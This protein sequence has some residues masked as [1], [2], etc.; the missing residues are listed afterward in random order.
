MSLRS[1]SGSDPASVKYMRYRIQSRS[2]AGHWLQQHPAAVL[3]VKASV[4][5][6]VAWLV[7]KPLGGLADDY[8]YYA[9]LGAVVATSTTALRS[10]RESLQTL[11]AIT[12]GAAV[13]LAALSLPLPR[14][15]GLVV[16]TGVG[17]ALGSWHVLGSRSSWVPITA[18]FVL[19]VGD[20]HPWHYA[21]GYGGFVALGAVVGIA[22]DAAAPQRPEISD[23]RRREGRQQQH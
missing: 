12:L 21:L 22:V 9:P 8:P 19:L 3:A 2:A 6:G 11:A 18:L 4:A 1:S 10:L 14:L 17:V 20:S 23:Q 13:A 15:A 7:V 16:T 5:A